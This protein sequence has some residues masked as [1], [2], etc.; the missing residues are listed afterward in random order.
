MTMKSSKENP[1]KCIIVTQN[2][3]TYKHLVMEDCGIIL[4]NYEGIMMFLMLFGRKN[5]GSTSL[6]YC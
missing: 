2:P 5:K 3:H 6:V 1:V 4:K